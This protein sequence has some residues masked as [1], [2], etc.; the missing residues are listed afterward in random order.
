[1]QTPA[2]DDDRLRDTSVPKR[3]KLNIDAETTTS[4]QARAVAHK[5]EKEL[6]EGR[7]GARGLD[8]PISPPLTR[9]HRSTTPAASTPIPLVHSSTRKPDNPPAEQSN[10]S[11]DSPKDGNARST[12]FIWSPVQLTRIR[13]LPESDN[14]DT[15]GLEDILGDPMIK[16]CWNFNFLFD[17]EF[18]MGMF[19][20]DVR[21]L[22]GVKIV[23]GFWR[24][25][26]GRRV[27]LMEAA[28]HYPN[29]SLISAYMPD[30]FGTH[31][32]KMMILFRHDDLAQVIIHTA[33]MIPKDWGNMTQAVWQSPLLPLLSS[34]DVIDRATD[35]P[36][37]IGSGERFEVDLMRYI[38]AY[39]N[40]LRELK[41]QLVRYDFSTIRAAFIGSTP[42]RQKPSSVNSALQ[43]SWGWL[44]LK[45]V[46]SGIPITPTISPED[47][48]EDDGPNIVMQV[49]SVATLGQ[50]SAWLDHF[51]S[52]L[53]QHKKP[54]PP[55][56]PSN[57]T[58]STHPS[59]QAQTP[60]SPFF[61]TLSQKNPKA[62]KFSL[63]FPTASEIRTSL[64]G[65]RSG[66]SI[67]TKLQ[68]AAQQKQLEY[69]RPI[70]CHWDPRAISTSSSTAANPPRLPIELSTEN[71]LAALFHAPPPSMSRPVVRQA[72][73]RSAAP[74]IKTYIRF[75]SS[76][77]T[78]IDWAM[79]TSANLSKQAWGE[80][81]SQK[82]EVWIQS[83]EVG[84]VVWPDLF[85]GGGEGGG[86]DVVM[87]PV[88]GRDMPGELDLLG[89]D[90]GVQEGVD[91]DRTTVVEKGGNYPKTIVG[92]RMPYDLP[93]RPY[94]QDEVPWCATD[95]H[96]I[97]DRYGGI[98][99]G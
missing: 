17:V 80:V 2:M 62:P 46:L 6:V 79:V 30:P 93:L 52:V 40:R 4:K 58:T 31:H 41:T 9:R 21:A 28:Q 13:D 92:F 49:S 36:H 29:V 98:W 60:S 56:T 15:V 20:E 65:Y 72:R 99:R 16:E 61:T 25:D 22:V 89:G 12:R 23:H 45:E 38:D 27:G 47:N 90:E 8:R 32:S 53:N 77:Q 94:G 50:T 34:S 82:G 7:N 42:S 57:I 78:C 54:L 69:L 81:E 75:A 48:Q 51:Q 63:I 18:L 37:P 91:M 66:G 76:T 39:G 5:T 68:S 55:S 35:Q 71:A 14:V 19:D 97:P 11:P 67:H 86:R 73:R 44:G 59:R 64:N 26:D 10:L 3:R 83:W 96:S 1:M 95:A 24:K 70:L 88:F 87:I 84:V 43:T 85:D 74:H 33:N